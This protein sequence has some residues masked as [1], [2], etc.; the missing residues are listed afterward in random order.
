MTVDISELF[1]TVFEECVFGSIEDDY[2]IHYSQPCVIMEGSWV[3]SEITVYEFLHEC[4]LWAAEQGYR[5]QGWYQTGKKKQY[6]LSVNT[7]TQEVLRLT[8]KSEPAA[9]FKACQW[10]HNKG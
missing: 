6:V 8:E 10:I 7:H 9:I 1:N 3:E 5:L 2:L 4:K